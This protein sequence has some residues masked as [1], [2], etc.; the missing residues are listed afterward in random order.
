MKNPLHATFPLWKRGQG[1][2]V[3][4]KNPSQSPFAKGRGECKTLFQHPAT[5]PNHGGL[6]EASFRRRTD[7]RQKEFWTSFSEVTW[8]DQCLTFDIE[9]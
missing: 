6:F 4:L 3:R 2:I 8:I 1:G 9:F 7:P 5:S